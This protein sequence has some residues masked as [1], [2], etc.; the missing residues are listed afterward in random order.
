ME[1]RFLDIHSPLWT[2]CLSNRVHDFYHLPEYVR[3]CAEQDAGEPLAFVARSGGN[4]FFVPLIVRPVELPGQAASDLFDATTPYGYPCP[5]VF[6]P[7][8]GEADADFLDQAFEALAHALRERRIISAFFRLHPLLPL[9]LAT[10]QRRGC[11]VQHGQTVFIDLALS[12]EEL[13]QQTRASHR[14]KICR[15]KRSHY[16]ADMALGRENL[17]HFVELYAETMHRV[18]AAKH[19]F[20]SRDYFVQLTQGISEHLHLCLIRIEGKVAAGGMFSETCGIVQY[21][22][23]GTKNEFLKH[24]GAKFMFDFVRTWAKERGNRVFHL[25]GGLGGAEDSLF[26]FKAGFSPMRRPFHTWRLIA[27]HDAYS[28]A[29][30]QWE[31]RAA[32]KADPPEGFFPAYRKRLTAADGQHPAPPRLPAPIFGRLSNPVTMEQVLSEN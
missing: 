31:R 19:Y 10:L 7:N 16:V 15:A 22:L 2:G 30:S 14:N 23:G 21:H 32:K 29:I 18:G 4:C 3:L 5:L 25:G 12:Q 13:W 27:D 1:Y 8:G 6:A 17:D 11:L 24:H 26:D 20:F 9:P 28:A